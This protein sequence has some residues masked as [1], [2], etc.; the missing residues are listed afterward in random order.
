MLPDQVSRLGVDGGN[1]ES[2][3]RR[4]E[5]PCGELQLSGGEAQLGFTIVKQIER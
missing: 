1:T 4:K 5:Q 2:H 3:Y